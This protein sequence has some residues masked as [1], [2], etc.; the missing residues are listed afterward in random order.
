VRERVAKEDRIA[1]PHL[2]G[3]QIMSALLGQDRQE[4]RGAL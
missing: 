1:A 3:Y 2:I 4:R